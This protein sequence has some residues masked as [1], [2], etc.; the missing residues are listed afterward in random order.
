MGT[1]A[2]NGDPC[3]DASNWDVHAPYAAGPTSD[4]ATFNPTKLNT[5]QWMESITN[6]GANIGEPCPELSCTILPA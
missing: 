5:T 3:C 1:Y 2:H 6:L 4:P